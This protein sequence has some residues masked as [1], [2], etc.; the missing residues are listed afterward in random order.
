[1]LLTRGRP[2]AAAVCAWLLALGA[3][4]WTGM[5]AAQGAHPFGVP[6]S[7]AGLAG[8]PGWLSAFFGQV[9]VWQTHFYRQLTAAVRAW[10]A[11]GGA[12][13]TLIGLS[14]AYGVFHALGPGHGKAVISSYVLANR[15][16]ARNG[17]LLALLSSLVQALVAI[18]M[19]AALALVFNA[20]AA[21]MNQATRWLELA[22]YVLVTLLGAWLVWI[23]AIRP[24][25]RRRPAPAMAVAAAPTSVASAPVLK[26]AAALRAIGVRASA[27]HGH[28][29]APAQPHDHDHDHVHA[30]HDDCG[31][32]H[33]HVPPPDQVAGPL[34]WRRA[35]SAIFAVGLRPCSGALI[36]LVFALSQGFFLAGVASALAMGLGTGLTVAAL[37][38][39][40]VAAGGAATTL[41]SRLSGVAAARLRYGVEALAALA[42]LAL[43]VLLLGGMLAGGG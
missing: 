7:G 32:G 14:F 31:C 42:V 18:A 41:G 1:M 26:G 19:V 22:S 30:H 28:A 8:G 11:D 5:A 12:A 25:L 9:S 27:P 10:Q 3:L 16:T 4:A 35:W 34:S 15:Q 39:L 43:G 23:K 33:A 24:L 40:A 6:E 13:W 21:V 2:I 37:A 20:T 38:C 17:A 36:V 29:V